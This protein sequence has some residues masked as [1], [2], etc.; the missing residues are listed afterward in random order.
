MMLMKRTL[1]RSPAVV[2]QQLRG[3]AKPGDHEGGVPRMPAAREDLKKTEPQDRTRLPP[4]DLCWMAMRR[5][6]FKCRSDPEFNVAPFIDAQ[7]RCMADPCATQFP[8][9]DLTYYTPSDKLNREYQRTWTECEVKQRKR[10]AVILCRPMVYN[11]RRRSA[12]R[13]MATCPESG[14]DLGLDPCIR[15]KLNTPCPRFKL[16]F[17]REANTRGCYAG[18]S[19][20]GCVRRRTKYPAYSECL[21]DPVPPLAPSQCTCVNQPPMCVVWNYFRMKK[22]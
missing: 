13:G 7:K 1:L 18:R 2:T 22:S 15:K 17:C 5:S 12:K 10:K 14:L 21:V 20:A 3:M 16:P 8:P 6:E 9:A 19:H 11:R 4:K